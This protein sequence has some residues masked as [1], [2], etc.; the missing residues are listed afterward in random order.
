MKKSVNPKTAKQNL[1]KN[2]F[3]GY[4]NL[5][6]FKCYLQHCGEVREVTW[7]HTPIAIASPFLGQVVGIFKLSLNHTPIEKRMDEER[8]KVKTTAE[9]SDLQIRFED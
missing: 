4:N 1:N 3:P 2:L 9:L 7:R 8:R 6:S 5:F